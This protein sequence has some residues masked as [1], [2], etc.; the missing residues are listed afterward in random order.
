MQRKN[1]I[2]EQADAIKDERKKMQLNLI[3][4]KRSESASAKKVS[5]KHVPRVVQSAKFLMAEK[6][7]A[8][9]EL[10]AAEKKK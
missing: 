7:E 9:K 2:L 4:Q 10:K 6:K 1:A 8:E 5:V 3:R